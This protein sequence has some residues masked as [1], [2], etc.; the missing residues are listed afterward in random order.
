MPDRLSIHEPVLVNT[1]GHCAGAI[2]FGILLYFFVVNWMRAHEGRSILPAL[3]AVL[4]MLWNVGSLIALAGGPHNGMATD[5]ITAASFSVLSLLPAVLLH[6]SLQADHRP[7]WMSGYVLSV[8]AI[9]LHIIDLLT[10]A[11]R[12]HYAALLL[13]TLGFGGLTVLSVF[14]EVRQR[15]QAAG[16]RLAGAMALFLFAISFVHFGSAHPRQMWEGEIALHHAGL[17]LALLVILQDYR[18][19]LLDTFL[20]FILNASL[21][22]GA[23]LLCVRVLQSQDLKRHLAHPFDAGLLFVAA[24]LLLTMFV[25]LRNRMQRLLT[26]AL[27]LRT[28]VEEPLRELHTLGHAA[29]SEA[30]YLGRAAETIAEFLSAERYALSDEST[31]QTEA[32][33]SPFSVLDPTRWKLPPWVQTVVPLR[34]ARGDMKSLL[35]GSR[36]GGRRYL[37]EDFTILGRLAAAVIEHVEQFRTLQMQQLVSQAE[38]RALQ[39]QINPHFLFNS[40]N[41]LYGT[42]ARDNT[43]AR[44]LVLNLADVFRYFLQADRTYIRVAEELKIVRAYLE[45]EE[46]RLGPKLRTEFVVDDVALAASIPSLSIQPLVENAIKHGVAS[47]SGEGF[48]RLHIECESDRI[49]V[50]ITNSGEW[51]PR[52]GADPGTGI[53]LTNVR[54]RLRLCYGEEADVEV[55]VGSGATTVRFTIPAKQ[56]LA[57]AATA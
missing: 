20:R 2:I 55:T 10:Q 44:R 43:E 17:P 39:A 53:G 33:A 16:S 52:D 22:A 45:I 8:I 26:R 6:I 19:L 24:C 21:G 54:R 41:T 57:L 1:I 3:A 12:F 9:G 46:L 32:L 27:F 47:R 42:I 25:Y 30:E 50:R 4:A 48:V 14:L 51:E 34:F 35:L 56:A 5:I 29:A 7:I 31:A 18:F 23:L 11:E 49:A 36:K 13:V 38:L 28:N 40:L 37:S 15:N